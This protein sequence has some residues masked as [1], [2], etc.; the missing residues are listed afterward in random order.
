[1]KDRLSGSCLELVMIV[2]VLH[3]RL[4][5]FMGSLWSD[6][7]FCLE[8][9]LITL[10]MLISLVLWVISFCFFHFHTS[11]AGTNYSDLDIQANTRVS[12]RWDHSWASQ[13]C[14]PL[15][16]YGLLAYTEINIKIAGKQRLLSFETRHLLTRKKKGKAVLP[17]RWFRNRRVQFKCAECL[18]KA[19][20]WFWKWIKMLQNTSV[21]YGNTASLHWHIWASWFQ[22][23]LC[24]WGERI[25]TW[26]LSE[27]Y[28]ALVW[29]LKSRLQLHCIN[30]G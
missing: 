24:F 3:P 21:F 18:T 30:P 20:K 6:I 13:D 25:V 28:L 9:K 12:L 27:A 15:P 16:L 8:S 14:W 1:M 29:R 4:G 17:C 11:M 7:S 19:N 26:P 23:A 5:R 10:C 22:F 2:F